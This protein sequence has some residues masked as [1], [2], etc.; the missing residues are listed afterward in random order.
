MERLARVEPFPGIGKTAICPRCQ[1]KLEKEML[2]VKCPN[3]S[4]WYHQ[5][6]DMPCWTYSEH[7]AI[8]Q[9]QETTLDAGYQ[10]TPE[11]M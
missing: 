10:W 5:T 6:E 1:L 11:D 3:C 2:S 9:Q 8:C 4:V 7:C